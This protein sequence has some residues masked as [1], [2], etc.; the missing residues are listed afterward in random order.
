MNT[1]CLIKGE[2]WQAAHNTGV[3]STVIPP[4]CRTVRARNITENYY[5]LQKDSSPY[6]TLSLWC[7]GLHALQYHTIIHI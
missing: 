6:S 4:L 5:N 1:L 7:L 2:K 3:Y